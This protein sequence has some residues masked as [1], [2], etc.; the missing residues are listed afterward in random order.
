MR[1]DALEE[2]R[3][4]RRERM[5]A[6][7]VQAEESPARALNAEDRAQLVAETERLE[8]LAVSRAARPDPAGRVLQGAHAAGMT[9]DVDPFV[10]V[11]GDELVL[12]KVRL[13]PLR[14]LLLIRPGEQEG[15][16]VDGCPPQTVG[17]HRSAQSRQ[18]SRPQALGVEAR[19]AELD[20]RLLCVPTHDVAG[21]HLGSPRL[22]WSPSMG[23]QTGRDGSTTSYW[24]RSRRLTPVAA[25]VLARL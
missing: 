7:A 4:L 22:R 10:D 21:H 23:A 8:D 2:P 15:R 11:V 14:N 12:E 9:R 6:F 18:Q 5:P 19:T 3:V 24:P 13:R 20:D 16:R 25:T 17:R 1:R